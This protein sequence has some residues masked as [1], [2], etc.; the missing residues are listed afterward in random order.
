M[1]NA[2]TASLPLVLALLGG[3]VLNTTSPQQTRIRVAHATVLT[4]V[5]AALTPQDQA[6]AEENCPLGL[7]EKD[8]AWQFGPTAL[9]ARTGYALEHSAVDKIPLWVCEHVVPEELVGTADRKDNFRPDP[10][11]AKGLRS[12]KS[13]YAGSKMDRG[14]MAPSANQKKSQLRN[15]ETFFLSN[16]AP[17]VGIGFNQHIWADLEALTRDWVLDGAVATAWIVTGPIFYDPAEESLPTADGF[18]E[19]RVIGKGAVSVPTHFYKI[20]LGQTAG[21]QFK[22]VAFVLENRV[23]PSGTEFDTLIQ[24]IDWIEQRTGLN[25][26]PGLDAQQE[27]QLESQPG[28]LFE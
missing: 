11:L 26:M 24:S 4:S 10:L 27:Q 9:V 17:Q 16:M 19:N 28:R 2:T 13:D 22:A 23:Y 1:K 5:A 18:V 21:Q 25:F 15:D 8:P 20:V 6:V 12:E 14:H 3:T 7:P